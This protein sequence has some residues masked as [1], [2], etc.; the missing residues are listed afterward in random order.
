M[1]GFHSSD[2]STKNSSN[3]GKPKKLVHSDHFECSDDPPSNFQR[4]STVGP[5]VSVQSEDSESSNSKMRL[6]KSDTSLTD[7]FVMISENEALEGERML[8][9]SVIRTKKKKKILKDGKY[10]F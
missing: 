9:G 7:S 5:E 2:I 3:K 1:V 6:S 8:D 4:C 10:D